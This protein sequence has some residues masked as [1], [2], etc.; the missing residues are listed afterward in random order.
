MFLLWL[1][2]QIFLLLSGSRQKLTLHVVWHTCLCYVPSY[3]PTANY[4]YCKRH[5]SLLIGLCMNCSWCLHADI[6]QYYVLP[7]NIFYHMKQVMDK[8][9]HYTC[10]CANFWILY[11]RL[12]Y[13]A[14]VHINLEDCIIWSPIYFTIVYS[15]A[16]LLLLVC[17][18]TVT[19]ISWQDD[20]PVVETIVP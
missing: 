10:F 18:S 14:I 8:Y 19:H 20:C 4:F 5:H 12:I 11:C 3:N 1:T 9:L 7:K 16:I 2:N 13:I 17:Y 6:L 15:L